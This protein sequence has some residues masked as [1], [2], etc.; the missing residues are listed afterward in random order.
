MCHWLNI[1]KVKSYNY[2]N[3]IDLLLHLKSFEIWHCNFEKK[4]PYSSNASIL[5]IKVVW[6]V[7]FFYLLWNTFFKLHN[8]LNQSLLWFSSICYPKERLYENFHYFY[9]LLTYYVILKSFWVYL[10]IQI[11][12]F[13]KLINKE[14]KMN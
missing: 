3:D 5:C 14:R 11:C 9:F 7:V 10:P 6:F 13:K 1:C 2:E 4:I 8:Q 12:L